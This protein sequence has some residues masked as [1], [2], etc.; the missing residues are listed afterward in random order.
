[1]WGISSKVTEL[2]V[3]DDDNDHDD[4]DNDAR[5]LGCYAE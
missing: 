2:L 5:L 1:M 3:Y 4:V